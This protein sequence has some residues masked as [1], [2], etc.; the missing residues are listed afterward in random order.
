MPSSLP[1]GIRTRRRSLTFSIASPLRTYRFL[2]RD[3][4]TIGTSACRGRTLSACSSRAC[5]SSFIL[6]P[7]FA[8]LRSRPPAAPSWLEVAEGSEPGLEAVGSLERP[9][10]RG[11]GIALV[12][13]PPAVSLSPRDPALSFLP[14][15]RGRHGGRGAQTLPPARPRG[16][17]WK[18]RVAQARRR[19]SGEARPRCTVEWKERGTSQIC[20]GERTADEGHTNSNR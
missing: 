7:R 4:V 8:Y 20:P 11:R 17:S 19:P 3:T 1:H 10:T 18:Q 15:R 16:T 14:G 12:S 6:F 2:P 9:R 5:P 13:D